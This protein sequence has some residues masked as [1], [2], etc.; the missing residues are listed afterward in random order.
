MNLSR[1]NLEPWSLR[2]VIRKKWS[3][4]QLQN[5]LIGL[6][7]FMKLNHSKRIELTNEMPTLNI[8]KIVQDPIDN[9][10]NAQLFLLFEHCL[11]WSH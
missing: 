8:S 4:L 2:N 11:A 9:F 3:S 5:S 7:I 6:K 10:D 1:C